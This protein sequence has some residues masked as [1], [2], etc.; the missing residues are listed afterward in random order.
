MCVLIYICIL[1]VGVLA[2][3]KSMAMGQWYKPYSKQRLPYRIPSHFPIATT[4]F[5]DCDGNETVHRSGPPL[6]T[7][8]FLKEHL[9]QVF[10]KYSCTRCSLRK[11]CVLG[12]ELTCEPLRA[13]HNL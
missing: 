3:R 5:T 2:E 6:R 10:E 11:F 13:H 12:G 9:V 7:R 1:I 4:I 8:N